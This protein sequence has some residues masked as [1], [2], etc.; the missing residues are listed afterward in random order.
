ML[1]QIGE[2]VDEHKHPW[3]E[4]R[5]RRMKKK[6]KKRKKRNEVLIQHA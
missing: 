3:K 1:A 2:Q 6:K 5:K 4:R